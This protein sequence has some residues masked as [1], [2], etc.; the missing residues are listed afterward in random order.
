MIAAKSKVKIPVSCVEQGRWRYK[1]R[2]FGSS[3]HFSSS[4]MR[5]SFK[6]SVT[7]SLPLSGSHASDQGKVWA[8]VARQQKS[9]GISSATSA[10]SDTFE[11]Y[12]KRVAEFQDKLKYV[13]GASGMAVA[14]G[15]RI[16]AVDLFDKP[17]ICQKVW[18][19]LLSGFVLDAL[20]SKS[21]ETQASAADV[22][23]MLGTASGMSWVKAE[24][25]GEGEEFRGD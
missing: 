25:V 14:V 9:L 6:M 13:D 7:N 24:P 8:E 17:A 12:K 21:D 23:D 1:S 16:V 3:D 11:K 2:H 19:R 4:K 22:H 5:M 18:N 10:M 15:N 20:E